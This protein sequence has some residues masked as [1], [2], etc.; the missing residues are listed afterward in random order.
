[1]YSISVTSQF[2]R[3]YK[4]CLNRNFNIALL[5]E[6]IFE[7]ESFGKSPLEYK[8]HQLKGKYKKHWECHIL[9]DWLLIWLPDHHDRIVKLVRTGTHSDLF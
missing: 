7:L 2:K 6:I 1:M 4:R 8:P 5:D 3:D 9:P